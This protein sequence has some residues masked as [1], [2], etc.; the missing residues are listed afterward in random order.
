MTNDERNPNDQ[1]QRAGK[2][3]RDHFR[4]TLCFRILSLG[5]HSSFVIRHSSFGFPHVSRIVSVKHPRMHIRTM[6]SRM[7]ARA[8]TSA[9]TKQQRVWS[10]PNIDF[11]TGI[12]LRLRMTL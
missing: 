7:A 5:L 1:R 2:H 6:N 10:E 8:P 9:L 11:P 4:A 12:M 3:E